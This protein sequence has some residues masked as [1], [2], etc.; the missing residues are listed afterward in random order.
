MRGGSPGEGLQHPSPARGSEIGLELE[1]ERE[2]KTIREIE[3]GDDLDCVE[4]FL[5]REARGQEFSLQA[6]CSGGSF[7]ER[8]GQLG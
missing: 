5:S 3:I 1:S 8:Y 2:C 6:G 7:R 4:P